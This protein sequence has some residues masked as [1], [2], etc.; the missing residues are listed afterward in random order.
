MKYEELS[1][2][3]RQ[4]I[5]ELKQ[6][7]PD[8]DTI[9]RKQLVDYSQKKGI[10]MPYWLCGVDNTISRG[11]YKIPQQSSNLDS[12]EQIKNESKN[13]TEQEIYER[14]KTTY[15][16]MYELVQAVATQSLNGLV[17]SG[18][19]GIGKSFTVESILNNLITDHVFHRGYLK[20]TGLYKLLWENR[21]PG[22]VI[23]LDDV[24]LWN[25]ETSLNILKSALELKESRL[26]CWGSEYKM[27]DQDNEEIPR[28]FEYQGSIIFLTNLQIRDMIQS[29]TKNSK[30]LEAIESRG[31]VL[32]LKIKSR[33]EILIKIKQTIDEGLLA[34]YGFTENETSEIFEF[35]EENLDKFHE[36]SLRLAEKVAK[37]YAAIPD[38][39]R[40]I[41]CATFIK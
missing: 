35:I 12:N 9:T 7:F 2:V 34:H 40:E 41:C 36:V 13:E 20:A 29:G 10:T 19:P 38:K 22:Q 25:C 30:H 28:Y 8:Q 14:I 17:I 11:I 32:D 1:Y 26:I 4:F 33:K 15:Q 37:V 24:D 6:Q 18:A 31:L 23:V 27:Q 39:W 5:N 3:K 21:N 16:T